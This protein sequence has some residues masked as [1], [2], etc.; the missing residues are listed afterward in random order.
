MMSDLCDK[1]LN[2]TIIVRTFKRTPLKMLS[3]VDVDK[4]RNAITGLFGSK[5]NSLL[6]R[7]SSQNAC[8]MVS[9]EYLGLQIEPNNQTFSGALGLLQAGKGDLIL[10]SLSRDLYKPWLAQS[11]ASSR[12]E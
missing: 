1:K 8:R 11:H 5:L 4:K 9:T 12:Q 6:H 7:K 2:L 10:D 3:I